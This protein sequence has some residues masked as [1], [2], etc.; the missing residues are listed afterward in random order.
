MA[1]KKQDK[2]LITGDDIL[3]EYVER[4]MNALKQVSETSL[5]VSQCACIEKFIS[6]YVWHSTDKRDQGKLML[7]QRLEGRLQEMKERRRR[8]VK[9][10]YKKEGRLNDFERGF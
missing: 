9:Y 7:W 10:M 8:L 2:I 5:K 4:L 6:H 3:I 1:R